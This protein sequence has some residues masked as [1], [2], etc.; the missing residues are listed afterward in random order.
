MDDKLYQSSLLNPKE[1]E[2]EGDLIPKK[3][4]QDLK[5]QAFTELGRNPPIIYKTAPMAVKYA[6]DEDGHSNNEKANS[7]F[8]KL[9]Q[10]MKGRGTNVDDDVLD[11]VIDTA[12]VEGHLGLAI[13]QVVGN[14][15]KNGKAISLEILANKDRL[16]FTKVTYDN[17]KYKNYIGNYKY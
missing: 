10:R 1:K 13:S 9:K 8:A 17:D 5:T 11:A 4:G 6:L 15:N 12:S 2:G 3:E 16:I 14:C 7:G